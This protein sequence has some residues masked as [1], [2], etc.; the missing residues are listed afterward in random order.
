[1]GTLA[2]EMHIGSPECAFRDVANRPWAAQRSDWSDGSKKYPLRGDPLTAV[3]YV[4]CKSST[5]LGGQRKLRYAAMFAVHS[6]DSVVPVDV[7][8]LETTHFPSAQTQPGE[9]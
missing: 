4:I 1:M 7:P 9:E 8:Q 3:L 2:R 6:D 5:N